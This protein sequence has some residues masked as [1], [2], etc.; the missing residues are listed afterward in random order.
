MAILDYQLQHYL[1]RFIK[2]LPLEGRQQLK[3]VSLCGI[4]TNFNTDAVYLLASNKGEAKIHGT[5]RCKNPFVC[6]VCSAKEMEWHRANIQSAIEL[7][8]KDYFGFMVSFAIPHVGIMGCREVIDILYET[9]SY[10]NRRTMSRSHGHVYHELNKVAPIKHHVRV[11]EQTWGH[12]HGWHHHFHCIFW[13]KRGDEAVVSEW[14]D[15]L[16]QFWLRCARTRTLKYWQ[17][18]K[19][20]DNVLQ[21]DGSFDKLLDRMYKEKTHHKGVVFS[22]NP[23]GSLSEVDSAEYIS[24]W[25]ADRE[26]TGNYRKEASHEGHFTPY[27]ILMEARTNPEYE[28]LYMEFCLAMTKKPVHHRVDFSQTGLRK[29][30][31]EW[32]KVHGKDLLL[33]QKKSQEVGTPT[34][35]YVVACFDKS[36][37]YELC[38]LD[39]EAPVI[40]NIM[41]L[42][43]KYTYLLGNYLDS[44]GIELLYDGIPRM[45]D[46]VEALYNGKISA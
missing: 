5:T 15:K 16:N 29:L 10:F 28:K 8:H 34:R 20:H 41:F 31:N 12:K 6:P 39:R 45:Y 21:I 3:T 23:D 11:C 44:L 1:R 2:K 35:W 14:E 4:S 30:V 18:H 46:E 25:G 42:A 27:Q 17:K 22:R 32:Q 36:Q 33:H 26:L 9:W 38:C 24:G 43:A 40:S 19:L 37:W 13:V 7:L